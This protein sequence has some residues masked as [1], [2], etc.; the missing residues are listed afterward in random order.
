MAARWYVLHVYSGFENKVRESILENAEKMGIADMFPEILVPSQPVMEVRRGKRVETDKTTFPGYVLIRMDL[1][2][3]TWNMVK[4]TPKVT[5]F[6][7]SGGRPVP[8]P[9]AE[10]MRMLNR[11]KDD[12]DKPRPSITFDIGE[13]VRITDGAFASM[14]GLVEDVDEGRAKLSVSVTIFGRSTPTE[15]D[16]SQVEKV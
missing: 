9:Q 7:G 1:N 13:E 16:Y 5:N 6:L 10:A 2:D 11:I 14:K 8:I 3:E 12:Q 15:L 4:N